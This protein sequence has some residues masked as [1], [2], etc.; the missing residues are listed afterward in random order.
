M[1]AGVAGA[2][3]AYAQAKVRDLKRV[4]RNMATCVGVNSE[5]RA[6]EQARVSIVS[7]N[8][9]LDQ[10]RPLDRPQLLLPW[11]RHAARMALHEGSTV[12]GRACAA[13]AQC[14]IQE[15]L[16]SSMLAVTSRHA[17]TAQL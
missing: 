17:A 3:L 11:A 16:E 14:C 10:C 5:Q 4:A 6:A 1:G 2:A 13:P 9:Q 8:C 7:L 15:L 12:L